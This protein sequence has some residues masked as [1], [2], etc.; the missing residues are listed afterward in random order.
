[1]S[2]VL[3]PERRFLISTLAVAVT[4]ALGFFQPFSLYRDGSAGSDAG[5][6]YLL[7]RDRAE[8][9]AALE[10]Y[11]LERSRPPSKLDNQ[12]LA[13]APCSSSSL[14]SRA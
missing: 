12:R 9:V 2:A 13:T 5:T 10:L 4:A 11:S 6:R 7:E 8:L 14:P 3:R 1:M